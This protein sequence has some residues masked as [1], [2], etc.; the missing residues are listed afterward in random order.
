MADSSSNIPQV[1]TSVLSPEIVLNALI[2]ALSPASFYGRNA[3]ACAALTFGYLG[4]VV[5]DPTGSPSLYRIPNGTLALAAGTTNYIEHL[6]G[7]APTSNTSG[8]T[9]GSIPDYTAITDAVS[10]TSY[11]DWRTGGGEGA[12]VSGSAGG[13]L[14][15]TYPNPTVGTNKVTNAKAAQMAANTVKG[16]NTGST[17]NAV[18]MTVAQLKTLIGV[19]GA[20]GGSHGTGLVGDPGASPFSPPR[21]WCED[22]DWHVPAFQQTESIIVAA[23]DESTALTT[24]TKLTFRMPYAMTLTGI[25]ASLTTA[26]ASSSIFTVDVK[27]NG[28]TILS[29]LITID[30]TETTSTTAAAAPV[31]STSSLTDDAEMT[32]IITQVGAASI[33]AGLK[34]ALIGHQ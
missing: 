25:R 24:G 3:Q 12:S 6:F 16:N 19:M 32:V 17:A 28:T 34:L 9:P 11:Y 30:N 2:D 5:F 33:A 27:M 18:D 29:T 1:E 8:F 21:F 23:S 10:V 20:S 13:D 7:Q 26:Q 14:T 4:A 15:G 22:A 31:I